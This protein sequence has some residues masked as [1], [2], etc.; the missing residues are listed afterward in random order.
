MA[1]IRRVV[2]KSKPPSGRTFDEQFWPVLI[3]LVVLGGFTMG[4]F[5]HY[6]GFGSSAFYA[7]ATVWLVATAVVVVAAAVALA[8]IDNRAFR[9]TMQLA[10]L[11][12]LLVH[13]ILLVVSIELEVF[14]R[15]ASPLL[16]RQDLTKKRPDVTAPEYVE[17]VRQ[18]RIRDDFARLVPTQSPDPQPD[19]AP[20]ER[21]PDPEQEAPPAPTQPTPAPEP[22]QTAHPTPAR[23]AAT[24]PPAPRLAEQDSRL[25]RRLTPSRTPSTNTAVAASAQH[26]SPPSATSRPQA[27]D[28]AV[29]HQAA[30]SLAARHA[31]P[32]EQTT[33]NVQ[34][35]VSTARRAAPQAPRTES[36]ATPTFPRQIVQPLQLPRTQVDLAGEPTQT[37]RTSPDQLQPQTTVAQQQTLASPARPRQPVEPTPDVDRPDAQ[38]PQRR[39]APSPR[40][41]QLAQAPAS[42]ANQRARATLRPAVESAASEV[43]P[44]RSQPSTA[45][46]EALATTAPRATPDAAVTI[47]S[48]SAARAEPTRA[49]PPEPA[50]AATS[51]AADPTPRSHRT[52]AAP[53]MAGAQPSSPTP[54]QTAAAHPLAATRVESN[55]ESPATAPPQADTTS[56]PL[57]SAVTRNDVQ[58]PVTEV[59][60]TP[61]E[62]AAPVPDLAVQ[63]SP[64]TAPA[65]GTAPDV[66]PPLVAATPLGRTAESRTLAAAIAEQTGSTAP[67]SGTS[68][69]A[70]AAGDTP[71][72]QPTAL[73]V[74]TARQ[75][76]GHAHSAAPRP[77]DAS[78][79][80]VTSNSVPSASPAANRAIA[81][82]SSRPA[83]ATASAPANPIPDRRVSEPRLAVQP[84]ADAAPTG[85]AAATPDARPTPTAVAAGR[86]AV[87]SEPIANPPPIPSPAAVD[88]PSLTGAAPASI[89]RPR[90]ER[91]PTL[92]ASP[93]ASTSA[94]RDSAAAP[95]LT[96]LVADVAAATAAVQGASDQPRPSAAT[97]AR[98][99]SPDLAAT[100]SQP[101]LDV[102]SSSTATQIERPRARP[103]QS[104]DSPSIAPHAPATGQPSRAT[105][106]AALAAS[107]ENIESPAIAESS[108]GVGNPSAEPARLA[109]SKAIVGT[110]GVGQGRNLDRARPAADSPALIVSAAALR[111][112]PM[113][114]A[115]PGSALSP[116]S[117]ALVRRASAGRP[118]PTASVPARV[119]AQLA[120]TAGS[121]QP[122]SL[123]AS[124]SASLARADASAPTGPVT[125]AVGRTE[126]DV[127]PSRVISE[128]QTGRGSGGGQP[129]LNFDTDVPRIARQSHVGGAP[130]A[131]LT[132]PVAA[133]VP[134]E[135]TKDGGGQPLQPAADI[136]PT[137]IARTD[138]GGLSAASGGPTQ[139]G[140]IGP[141][142]EASQ[143]RAPDQPSPVR[144]ELAEAISDAAMAGGGSDEDEQER[145][146][147]LAQ[148]TARGPAL[149]VDSAAQGLA[150]ADELLGGRPAAAGAPAA[151][152][153]DVS[154]IAAT[155]AAIQPAATG[156]MGAS[157]ASATTPAPPVL[158]ARASGANASLNPGSEAAPTSM[159]ARAERTAQTPDA[160]TTATPLDQSAASAGASRG[161]QPAAAAVGAVARAETASGAA[162]D[163]AAIGA[164]EASQA[165]A[166]PAPSMAQATADVDRPHGESPLS[167]PQLARA[168]RSA[169]G[170]LPREMTVALSAAATDVPSG[171][172]AAG[173]DAA[174][175]SLD[176]ADT[177]LARATSTDP[178]FTGGGASGTPSDAPATGLA[179]EPAPDA[180]PVRV[181]RAEPSRGMPG[182]SSPGDGQPADTDSVAEAAAIAAR[183]SE[184][185]V[186]PTRTSASGGGELLAAHRTRHAETAESSPGHPLPGGGTALPKRAA[187]GPGLM[188]DQVA[189]A[190]ALPGAPDSAGA[191]EG[192]ALAASGDAGHSLPIGRVASPT[193]GPI[194]AMAGRETLDV[195][196]ASGPGLAA[197]TR[198]TSSA[199]G[200]GPALD[201]A[202]D[203]QAPWPRAERATP[204]GG[205]VEVA[206][207]AAAGRGSLDSD[208]QSAASPGDAIDRLDLSR[209]A[210]EGS[211]AVDIT[212]VEGPGGLESGSS[213]DVGLNTRRAVHDSVHVSLHAARF[214]RRE[215]SARPATSTAAIVPTESFRQR[216]R[217]AGGG[218]G[219]RVGRPPP[220]TE[221]TIDLGLDFLAR[222]QL[223]DGSWSLQSIPGEPVTQVSD[224]AATAL[225][226][227]AFQGAGYNHREHRYADVVRGGIEYLLRGQKADGDLYQPM[228]EQS[229]Q[230]C[231]LYSHALASLAL[232]E[233]YGMTQDPSLAE[234]AQRALS[235]ILAAQ[236]A[237]RGGWRYTPQVGSDTSVTGWMM[238]ALKSGELAGLTVPER[239][240][241]NIR[242]WLDKAQA[243]TREPHLYRYN[244]FAPNT[245][246]QMHG[247]APSKTMTAVGLLMRLYLGWRRDNP[248]MIHGAEYLA[249]NL[250]AL[251]TQASPQRDTYYWYYATQVMFHMGGKYWQAWNEQLHPLLVDTQAKQG[252]LAGSWDP[253]GAIP[254]R[255]GPQAGRLYVTTLNILSLEIYYR[256]L[257][258]YEDTLR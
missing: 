216:A 227:L 185:S 211:V 28:S 231:W 89:R 150:A 229:N 64:R 13:L 208:R 202:T 14:G 38:Q 34:P 226:V 194:G 174:G 84:A 148:R 104:A 18:S 55:A 6:L 56:R 250:P 2:R 37:K 80:A 221:E 137:A 198:R 239:A 106:R 9:R 4:T 124:A 53:Q 1:K 152:A 144:A 68:S 158:G 255:W 49:G 187:V 12:G 149:D 48:A 128:G 82:T 234:P 245:P 173:S 156:A 177:T 76:P 218:W 195:T 222:Q 206:L 219:P 42:V 183:G 147:R 60:A 253:R 213:V 71:Q 112:Q 91:A 126:I 204:P 230:A 43:Q 15:A 105:T 175:P 160:A 72:P 8:R 193:S 127:G 46:I 197:G 163:A 27:R 73:A 146:R 243:S 109:M 3:A 138:A 203:V 123:A 252:P 103:L 79:D 246:Q 63:P 220:M 120:L 75:S 224:T 20:L 92:A 217:E 186:S 23:Q 236:Q 200:D 74:A 25:S 90:G 125:G 36:T 95:R 96:D 97:V 35:A 133:R 67:P 45:E 111:P 131:A 44:V 58:T 151:D 189:P 176:A 21:Q 47:P 184:A 86:Q 182:P 107:P 248:N 81:A 238:M 167:G 7:N 165:Q 130:R 59:P 98:Q 258:L 207:L 116:Q 57:A 170:A 29:E 178:A 139:G 33:P 214:V 52:D 54:R 172:G 157:A 188:A 241:A 78:P 135:P 102:Q 162:G 19:P 140:E 159:L 205:G 145:R 24:E 115:V 119:D 228:D 32:R 132:S 215:P 110:A 11:L 87:A 101:Q 161:D 31:V 66:K 113:Q 164:S 180:P 142:T 244:P 40:Q 191:D 41:P 169:P 168:G 257:P 171:R 62:P 153:V 143:S 30:E 240:Y 199:T 50:P 114:E 83:S 118:V 5:A 256:H 51:P 235:F 249:D 16:T 22:P 247:R 212:A 100:Y 117:A 254:D 17:P 69:Q 251:G 166:I 136:L 129:V 210:T 77:V 10:L 237:E 196:I 88:S 141:P 223:G 121:H 192:P 70:A 93:L 155:A 181:A 233:A 108:R 26:R 122:E 85:A 232:S 154:R 225:A 179:G 190:V 61:A 99:A 209:Q 94:R 242:D 201:M 65:A 39:Q 134:T